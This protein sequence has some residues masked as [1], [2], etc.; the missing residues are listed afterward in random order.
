M[1]A[2]HIIDVPSFL[3]PDDVDDAMH[4]PAVEERY[5]DSV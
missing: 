1:I 4:A 2:N 3:N 5:S